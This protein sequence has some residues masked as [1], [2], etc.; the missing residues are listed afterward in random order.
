MASSIQE[1]PRNWGGAVC[2][3]FRAASET[4]L[5][6]LT[7]DALRARS[8]A[9]V[10]EN[11]RSSCTSSV[12]CLHRKVDD[13]L[14]LCLSMRRVAPEQLTEQ[15]SM[16]CLHGAV[17]FQQPRAE[18]CSPDTA[19]RTAV[20]SL[21]MWQGL[22]TCFAASLVASTELAGSTRSVQFLALT[23]VCGRNKF[24]LQ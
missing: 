12:Q 22:G 11:A 6:N 20:T 7:A 18:S 8:A 9:S 14:S 13:S 2:C 5:T 3:I 23:Q 15:Q 24:V 4:G 1:I 10:L 16:S 19:L 21:A 17:R